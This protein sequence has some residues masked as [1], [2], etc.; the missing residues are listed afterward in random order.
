MKPFKFVIA[1][2]A[3]FSPVASAD[4]C[5]IMAGPGAAE[6]RTIALQSGV[7]F[8]GNWAMQ[9]QAPEGNQASAGK[10]GLVVAHIPAMYMIDTE[11]LARSAFMFRCEQGRGSISLDALPHMLA[12]SAASIDSWPLTFRFGQGKAFTERWSVNRKRGVLLAPASSALPL[13]LH[14]VRDLMV[15]TPGPTPA[16]MPLGWIYDLDGIDQVLE[17]VCL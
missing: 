13:M 16:D 12:P 11:R 4:F 9:Q 7:K 17:H 2:L 6:C 10:A 8:I 14:G 15:L 3:L 5:D 1:A